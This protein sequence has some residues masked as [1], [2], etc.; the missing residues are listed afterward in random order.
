MTQQRYLFAI[1][2]GGGTVPA[3]TSV[4][5]AL[6]A[7]G[8]DVRV[9]A[10]AVLAPDVESTGA[11]HVP[12]D[13]APQRPDLSPESMLIQDWDAKTP[14]EA[15]ARARDGVMVGPAALFAADVRREL[16]RRPAD[17]VVGNIFLFGAQIGAEAEGVPFAFLVPNLL[18]FPGSGTPPLGPGL[19]PA[20]GPLGRLRDAALTRVMGRLFDKGLDQ[21]NEVRRANGLEPIASVL[22]NFERADR[23]LML[24]SRAFDYE[25]FSPP[26]NVR[27]VGPRLDDPVW[28]GDWSPPPGDGPLVLVGMSSTYMDHADVLQRV[29]SALGELPVRGVVTTGPTIPVDAIDAPP[30]VTVVRRAPH[31]EV[32]RHASAVVTHAGH[33]TVI[34]ALAAGVPVVA[35]PLGRDQLDNA[36][37]VAHHGA[38]LRLKPKAK[39]EAIAR[40]V[41]RVIDEPSFATGAERLAAAIAAETAEDR[42]AAELEQLAAR[43]G[44][45]RSAPVPAAH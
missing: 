25:G 17:V 11:E 15:F 14:F 13:E 20:R 23:L 8:H 16:Q 41:R 44:S 42:A 22:Q 38:G 31:S 10:D 27:V 18:S 39:P 29:A 7:R 19:K 12:W 37:R 3:D 4:I 40:A 2:D 35:I 21:L 32:L 45:G 9:L 43:N 24:T 26:P 1:T 30:N 28:V 6:V 36:A 34:K 5:R 33:G